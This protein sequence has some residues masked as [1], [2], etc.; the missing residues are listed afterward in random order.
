MLQHKK[1]SAKL[2]G[3]NR[4]HY[5]G[6]GFPYTKRGNVIW[7]FPEQVPKHSNTIL[8]S[9]CEYCGEKSPTKASFYWQYKNGI[10]GKFCCENKVC[11]SQH[12]ELILLLANK[13]HPIEK[14]IKICSDKGLRFLYKFKKN[15]RPYARCECIIHGSPVEV[16][17]T[18]LESSQKKN[19]CSECVSD[20]KKGSK[21]PSYNF[22]KSDEER[23]KAGWFP[24]RK[25][26]KDTL[27]DKDKCCVACQSED[28]L[29]GHHLIY[30]EDWELK[31]DPDN[32]VILCKVCHIAKNTGFH[33]KYG[34]KWEFTPMDFLKFLEERKKGN[35]KIDIDSMKK[36]IETLLSKLGEDSM[37]ILT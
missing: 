37:H 26:W 19:H 34:K 2:H 21:N 3:K 10:T 33:H 17:L 15:E 32:G 31:A 16:A 20:S 11:Q 4:K 28:K 7:V 29:E 22:S 8:P 6:M 30:T 5:E 24:G 25:K 13:K 27:L 23:M 18:N 12:K 36:R 14:L 9:I 35:E 1:I